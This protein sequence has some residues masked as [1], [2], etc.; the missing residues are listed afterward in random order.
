MRLKTFLC[1]II[2]AT[3][4]VI[5]AWSFDRVSPINGKITITQIDHSLITSLGSLPITRSFRSDIETGIMGPGWYLDIISHLDQLSQNFLFVTQAEK[6]I[7]LVRKGNKNIYRGPAGVRAQVIKGQWVVTSPAG[8]TSIYDKKGQEI[9]RSDANGN[10]IRFAYDQLGHL[11]EIQAVTGH[12][13]RIRYADNGLL[14]SI[15]DVNGRQSIYHYDAAGRLVEVQDANGRKTTYH[16]LENK[17]LS[18]VNYPSGIKVSFRYDKSGKVSERHSSSGNTYTYSY[19]KATRIT[20]HDGFWWETEYN[21]KGLPLIHRDSLE[22]EQSWHWN[23]QNQLIKRQFFDGSFKK[24]TYDSQGRMASQETGTGDILKM[25][26]NSANSRLVKIDHNGA[27]TRFTYDKN[28]N[29]LSVISPAGRKAVYRYDEHGRRISITDGEGRTTGFEYD[30]LGNMVKQTNP[31]KSV[32]SW[33]YNKNGRMTRQIDPLGNFTTIAYKLGGMIGSIARTGGESTSYQYN[34][35]GQLI[36]E[37]IG[38][39]TIRYTYNKRGLLHRIDYPDKMYENITYD[40]LGNPLKFTDVLG[41]VTRQEFDL[42]NRLIKTRAPSGM[43][44]SNTFTGTGK[45]ES[46]AVGYSKVRIVSD[47]GGR[48]VRLTDPASGIIRIAKDKWG[49]ETQRVFPGGGQEQRQYDPDGFLKSVTLPMGDTWSFKHNR[50]GQLEKVIFP[51]GGIRK[52]A[53]APTGRIASIIYPSGKKV[54]YRYSSTGLLLETT[55]A[56]GQK[57]KYQYDKSGRVIRKKMP[58]DNWNY[59][60]DARGNL[61]QA[62]N[63]MFTVRYSYDRLGQL[64]QTEYPQWGKVIKYEYD[65]FGRIVGRTDPEENKTRYGYDKLGRVSRIR[66]EARAGTAFS[67][68]YDDAGRLVKRKAGNKTIT[69]HKYDT[70][71]RVVSIIH[72]GQAGEL[73]AAAAYR[74]DLD[75]NRIEVIDKDEIKS[76]YRYDSEN[77]LISET[78]PSGRKAYVYGSGGKRTSVTGQSGVEVYRYDKAGRLVQAGKSLFFYDADGN[79]VSSKNKAGTTRYF[80]DSENNLIKVVIPD[81][82]IVAYGYGPFGKRIWKEVDSKRTYYLLDGDNLLQKLSAEYKPL[83]TYLYAG[84]DKLLMAFAKDDAHRFFHQDDLGSVLAVS[85]GKGKIIARYHYDAFGN[86]MKQEGKDA[87]QPFRFTGRPLDSATGLYDLRARFYDPITGQFTSRDPLFGEI[88]NPSTLSTYQYA[89]NNPLGYIDPYGKLSIGLA[90]I[91]NALYFGIAPV[92]LAGMDE[93]NNLRTTM[94]REILRAGYRRPPPPGVQ[95]VNI[96]ASGWEGTGGRSPGGPTFGGG[97]TILTPQQTGGGTAVAPGGAGGGTRIAPPQH[98]PGQSSG[99]SWWKGLQQKVQGVGQR[100]QSGWKTWWQETGPSV[101]EVGRTAYKGNLAMALADIVAEPL[102]ATYHGEDASTEVDEAARK[103]TGL[104]IGSAATYVGGSLLAVAAPA[105]APIVLTGAAV[106]STVGLA[107]GAGRRLGTAYHEREAVKNAERQEVI[108]AMRA[109]KMHSL[110]RDNKARIRDDI[111]DTIIKI[112]TLLGGDLKELAELEME[113]ANRRNRAVGQKP[114]DS[115]LRG[116]DE[117]ITVME[118]TVKNW[119]LAQKKYNEVRKS[120]NTLKNFDDIAEDLSYLGEEFNTISLPDVKNATKL[121][122]QAKNSRT[123]VELSF[124]ETKD[125]GWSGSNLLGSEDKEE[126]GKGTS[127]WGTSAPAESVET[128]SS[129]KVKGGSDEFAAPG[130]AQ[131]HKAIEETEKA[132]PGGK[133]SAENLKKFLDGIEREQDRNRAEANEFLKEGLDAFGKSVVAI[134]GS[135]FERKKRPP[136]TPAL[137]HSPGPV[138]PNYNPADGWGKPGQVSTG[139]FKCPENQKERQNKCA[140]VISYIRKYESPSK[141]SKLWTANIQRAY[142][143]RAQCCGYRWTTNAPQQTKGNENK[144]AAPPPAAPQTYDDGQTQGNA[145]PAVGMSR[146]EC[147]HKF[148][149]ECAEAISLMDVSADPDCEVCKKRNAANIDQCISG[150]SS[151]TSDDTGDSRYDTRGLPNPKVYY[152]YKRYQSGLKNYNYTI[153]KISYAGMEGRSTIYGPDTFEGC[154]T[155][156]KQKGYW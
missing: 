57:I 119:E 51:D 40:S 2:F 80:Y 91:D 82:K 145:G 58:N 120:L 70:T 146:T 133:R 27:I 149:P 104:A 103:L 42:L 87:D 30:T 142:S 63:G 117:R 96:P 52:L 14:S 37:T 45:L 121:L 85:N 22:R 7:L 89:F 5:P 6:P 110:F 90:N 36:K 47:D 100:L 147:I 59:R 75:G 21:K 15:Q 48:T 34:G 108:Y 97:Q 141:G 50:A 95:P 153:G 13:L 125:T 134:G 76:V 74:Y 19:N 123:K 56:R 115:D 154:S 151:S 38:T 128:P 29:L 20:R 144:T 143:F 64:I 135:H 112:K 130:S 39:H 61:V 92:R 93:V 41:R 46:I 23:N 102:S 88:D 9:S 86:V 60:Y 113:V 55:N 124:V 109:G 98:V 68:I 131:A 101:Q 44:M 53:Y 118:G 24:Y 129:K 26:Y 67:F 33:Q 28:S 83:S 99:S 72:R 84:L 18:E 3:I 4:S 81:G 114:T 65:K 132:R 71:G 152:V 138:G 8:I 155:W 73:L 137:P 94:A 17:R 79:L 139:A 156:L 116:I 16:Y 31:D 107:H 106:V 148:C 32:I 140:R 122:A 12:P 10:T 62:G 66:V 136:K 25:A 54:S 127:G 78:G 43:V 35:F 49:H 126:D 150:G 11:S 69:D 111:Q 1:F 77:R 105:A